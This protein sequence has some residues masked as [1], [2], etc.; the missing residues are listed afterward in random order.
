LPF[1]LADFDREALVEYGI[2]QR[3]I[4]YARRYVALLQGTD[5]K[6][7]TDIATGCY[8]GTSALLHEVIEVRIL[9][10]RDRWLLRR[11]RQWIR[12][13]LRD[14]EDAHVEGLKAEY[15]YLQRVIEEQLGEQIG[16]SAL[17]RANTIRF[18]YDRLLE[19]ELPLPFLES[20][21]EE[22]RRADRLLTRLKKL[23]KERSIC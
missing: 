8:Y 7:Y 22:V 3:E 10:K 11:S 21:A 15:V 2:T 14:N 20:T 16:L 17:V 1:R 9:L 4:E 5:S 6:T 19:S 13:F 18:D 12:K 23:G